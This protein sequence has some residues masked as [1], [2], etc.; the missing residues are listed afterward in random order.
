MEGSVEQGGRSDSMGGGAK[1]RTETG[2]P[3]MIAPF[4]LVPQRASLAQMSSSQLEETSDTTIA[5]RIRRNIEMRC[6]I[7]RWR[8]PCKSH[9]IRSFIGATPGT[10]VERGSAIPS[11]GSTPL[12]LRRKRVAALPLPLALPTYLRDFVAEA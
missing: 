1:L 5:G 6:R 12:G 3:V 8:V 4:T 7:A 10:G 11:S 2:Q 9:G